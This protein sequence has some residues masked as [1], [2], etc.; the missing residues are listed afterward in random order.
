MYTLDN[1]MLYYFVDCYI[2]FNVILYDI[3][4]MIIILMII[5]IMMMIMII[6]CAAQ[7][8][9]GAQAME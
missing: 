4:I 6:Y 8:L 2:I 9:L 5:M 7:P 3:I 1:V